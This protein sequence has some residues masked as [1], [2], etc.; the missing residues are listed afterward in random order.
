MK[1]SFLKDLYSVFMSRVL[2]ILAGVGGAVVTARYLGPEGNGIIASLMVYPSLFM[3]IGSLGIRQAAAYFV[4]QNRYS[5]NDIY[6]AVLAIWLVTSVFCLV[7]TYVL[8]KYFTKGDYSETLIMLAIIAIPFSLYNTYSSGIF[9]GKQNIKEFNQI[10][11]IPAVL[12][13]CFTFLL[14]AIFPFGVMGSMLGTFIGVAVLPFFIV[15]KMKKIVSVKPVFNMVIIKSMLSLGIVYA[16]SLLVTALNYKVDIILLNK[17]STVF[18]LGIYSKSANI[19]QYLWEIP[20]LVST[21]VFSRSVGAKDPKEISLKVC[22]LLRFSCVLILVASVF[23]YVLSPFIINILFGAKF[24]QSAMVLKILLPG[25]LLLTV[26]KVLNMDVA[27]KGKPWL[28]MKAMVPAVIINI[29][30]NIIWIPNY[31]ANGSAMAS[32]VSYSFA[33]IM[34]LFVYSKEVQIPVSVIF[35]FTKEDRDFV[36]DFYLKIVGKLPKNVN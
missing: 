8:I 24:A 5:L 22:R 20:T 10:N 28:S 32:L 2:V 29:V 30:L 34:F 31:G 36:R 18:E 17:Y 15:I 3:T 26:F 7:S 35:K 23:M 16:I 4:G 21:L 13:F 9:L 11:W 25:V 12:N 33:A 14:V 27:G 6:G 19:V 1:A